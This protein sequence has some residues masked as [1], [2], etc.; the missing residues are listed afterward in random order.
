MKYEDLDIEKGKARTLWQYERR[1]NTRRR[2]YEWRQLYDLE[3]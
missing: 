3:F 2:G 1:R